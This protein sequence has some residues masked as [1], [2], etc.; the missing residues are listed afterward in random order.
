[1]YTFSISI[2]MN[3]T[4]P[5]IDNAKFDYFFHKNKNTFDSWSNNTIQAARSPLLMRSFREE[6]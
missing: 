4:I 6:Q 5:R 1:M 2:M 3:V